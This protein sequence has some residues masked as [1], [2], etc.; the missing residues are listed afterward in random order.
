[1]LEVNP[2]ELKSNVGPQSF[3]PGAVGALV[4]LIFQQVLRQHQ[5]LNTWIFL[6]RNVHLHK[7]E[8]EDYP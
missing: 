4:F 8:Y 2:A 1:M 3:Y 5:Q 7:M 6:H